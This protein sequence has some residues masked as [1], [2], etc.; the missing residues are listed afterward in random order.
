M[1]RSS[2]QAKVTGR[3]LLHPP[4]G[5][6]RQGSTGPLRRLPAGMVCLLPDLGRPE[7]F[8]AQQV[9][10]LDI[11]GQGRTELEA[12]ADLERLPGLQRRLPR[13]PRSVMDPGR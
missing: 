5:G 2:R 6:Q 11:R 8:I 9:G 7:G 13:R 3:T 4:A 1:A 10:A 12:I